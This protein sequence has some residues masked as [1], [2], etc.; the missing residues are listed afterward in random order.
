[1]IDWLNLLFNSFWILALALAL[2][3]LGHTSWQASEKKIRLRD[4]LNQPGPQLALNLAG[5]LFSLGL[6][7]TSTRI[8]EQIIW[9]VLVALFLFQIVYPYLNRSEPG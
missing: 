1:M 7:L 4:E 8:W 6:A 2:A 5:A 3:A 9:F